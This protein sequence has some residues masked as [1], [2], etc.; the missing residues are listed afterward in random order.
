M[1]KGLEALHHPRIELAQ[2]DI[3]AEGKHDIAYMPFYKTKQYADIENELKEYERLKEDIKKCDCWKEHKALEIVRN[4]II[5]MHDFLVYHTYSSFNQR[6]TLRGL[7][8]IPKEEYDLVKEVL[9]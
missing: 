7:I 8:P 3:S 9:L 6:R 1:S 5:D 2:I 4:R